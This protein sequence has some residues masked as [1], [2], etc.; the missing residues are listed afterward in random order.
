M[1]RIFNLNPEQIDEI[2][3]Q[4]HLLKDNDII[5]NE[6]EYGS[7][8][9]TERNPFLRDYAR[10]LYSS[11]F[12]RL[13][14]KMQIVGIDSAAFYR[15]RLTHSLEVAQIA[16]NIAY[17][18]AESCGEEGKMYTDDI[19]LIGAAALAHDIGHPAFGHKGERV[20]NDLASKS[21][22]HFEGN[23]QNFR[24]LRCLEQKD[25][26]HKG[27]NLTN[28]TLLAINKYLVKESDHVKKFMYEDDY[29][30]LKK[31]REKIT[32][33]EDSRTLDVQIIELADDIAYAVHD[34]EDGLF[35]RNFSIDE[36][37]FMLN[38]NGKERSYQQFK[39]FVDDA[40]QY[41]SKEGEANVQDYST[42]FRKRLTSQLTDKFVMDI[43][44]SNVSDNDA[45]IHGTGKNQELTLNNYKEL[46]SNLKRVVFAGTTRYDSVKLYESRG[47]VVIRTL[48]S[49]YFSKET[50]E[51]GK[52]LPPDYRPDKLWRDCKTDEEKN[53]YERSMARHSIDYIAGMMDTFA[54]EAYE[55]LTRQSFNDIDIEQ[56]CELH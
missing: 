17:I 26:G 51:D 38:K 54:I 24:V 25:P 5:L 9:Y 8:S 12:R 34:L 41:S 19:H 42:L 6:R 43:T 49:I 21:Q 31:I 50:D 18:L 32:G 40:I 39:E 47:E 13:Q 10:V 48:F 46:L 20:L 28:R 14:G 22:L 52:L 23:A 15:N 53:G 11:S 44:L 55:R 2:K 29:E 56:L 7:Q 37:L 35:L 30:Y 4:Y 16:T 33:L 1:T 45:K 3:R 27:L 36:V